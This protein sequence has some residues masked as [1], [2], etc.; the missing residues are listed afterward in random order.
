ME[1]VNPKPLETKLHPIAAK[2]R[3]PKDPRPA[4]KP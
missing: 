1:T 2:R 3:T 4:A